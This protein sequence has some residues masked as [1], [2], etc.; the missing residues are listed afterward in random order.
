M[1]KGVICK[2]SEFL[3]KA[4]KQEWAE[5]RP[6]PNTIDLSDDTLTA[7]KTY[8]NWLYYGELRFR[9]PASDLARKNKDYDI[10]VSNAHYTELVEAYL[11]GQKHLD[12][13]YKSAVVEHLQKY[14]L[15]SIWTIPSDVLALLYKGTSAQDEMRK[16]LVQDLAEDIEDLECWKQ[17]VG[18]LPHEVLVDLVMELARQKELKEGG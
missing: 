1:H 7:V 2:S 13:Q 5:Q 3:R 4:L 18:E 8:V 14:L 17:D 6:A 15:D 12:S 10:T 16:I 11:F 9:S